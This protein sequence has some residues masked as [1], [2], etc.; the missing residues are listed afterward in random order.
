MFPDD[1]ACAEYLERLRWPDG[2]VCL[3]CDADDEP[4]RFVTRPTQLRCRSCRADT[5]LTAGTI[6]QDSKLPLLRWFWGAYLVTSETPGMSALQFRRQLGVKRYEPAFMMLHK[7]RAAMIRPNRDRIGQGVDWKT[8]EPRRY[9]VELDEA[10]VGGKTRGKG[11]GVTDKAIV[12][13]AV[14]V[15]WG[16]KEDLVTGEVK[17]RRYAG[18]LRLRVVPGR[19]KES[20]TLF[21]LDNIEVGTRVFT[22]GWVGYEDFHLYFQHEPVLLDK[23]TAQAMTKR[24]VSAAK[25]ER[26]PLIH[27]VFSNLKTWINGT[28]HGVSPKHLQA[29]L[30]EFVFRFNRRFYPMTAFNAVLGIGTGVAAPTYRG[31]YDGEW[32]HP[33]PEE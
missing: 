26:M 23:E 19:D 8:K 14:E 2:F 3:K 12:V 27:L 1:T 30:N 6:M 5:R 33:N 7:L 18:R 20:L 9:D 16:L 28:H 11:K 32:V 21:A 25:G 24:Q 22:D 13:G 4:Y 17:K 10:Y 31:L 29:Y 15:R